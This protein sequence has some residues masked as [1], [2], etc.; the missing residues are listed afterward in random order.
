MA[1]DWSNPAV[2]GAALAAAISLVGVAIAAVAGVLGA[3]A[4]ARIG[5][6]AMAQEGLRIRQDEAESR[7]REWN[8]RRIEDTRAQLV[9]IADG[10][11][12]LMEK[13]VTR[14]RAHLAR[15]NQPLLAN[16]RLVGDV[17]ALS[18]LATAVVDA[19]SVLK[20]PWILRAIRLTATNPFDDHHRSAM[21][22]ARAAVLNALERQQ[23]RALRDQALVELTADAIASIPELS[24]ASTTLEKVRID[25]DPQ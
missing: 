5:A 1:I 12:A 22:D 6:H 7:V 2:Q 4:G 10:F 9:S 18:L 24:R 17:R 19:T 21:V 25:E 15:V 8:V 23:E 20:G 3:I 16:A 13:D 14:A 11:L